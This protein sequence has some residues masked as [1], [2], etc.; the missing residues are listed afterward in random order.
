MHNSSKRF[1]WVW[2][3]IWRRWFTINFLFIWLGFNVWCISCSSIQVSAL[4][5]HRQPR[6]SLEIYGNF[7]QKQK[8]KKVRKSSNLYKV[9][10]FVS[11]PIN[12]LFS[13]F[14]IPNHSIEKF[15]GVHLRVYKCNGNQDTKKHTTSLEKTSCQFA[16]KVPDRAFTIAN[17]QGSLSCT[18]TI[19]RISPHKKKFP[20]Q[21][22]A[23]LNLGTLTALVSWCTIYKQLHKAT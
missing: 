5:I 18:L 9:S 19:H 17:H 7:I 16:F 10:G 14:F 3:Q 20:L 6:Q 2:T 4:V 11:F 21:V 8:K 22:E 15:A 1:S 12:V 13:S 23:S